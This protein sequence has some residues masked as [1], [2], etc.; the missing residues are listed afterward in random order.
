[1]TRILVRPRRVG[2]GGYL[3]DGS[4]TDPFNV[5]TPVDVPAGSS[6][7]DTSTPASTSAGGGFDFAKIASDVVKGAQ[8][9]YGAQA[10]VSNANYASQL[11]KVQAQNAINLAKAQGANAA[12]TAGAGLPSPT[13]LLAAG[14][15][16]AAIMLLKR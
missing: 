4:D 3:G 15:G 1:M 9:Y 2:F 7:V 13:L 16:L 11:A 14:V 10:A 8:T 12:K 5:D 6:L